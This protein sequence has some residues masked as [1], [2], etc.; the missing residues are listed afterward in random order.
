MHAALRGMYGAGL[1]LIFWQLRLVIYLG[2]RDVM[3]KIKNK[4]LLASFLRLKPAM[5]IYSLLLVVSWVVVEK[6]SRPI[7]GSPEN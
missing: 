7:N 6:L 4:H 3:K 5:G 1:N 2:P